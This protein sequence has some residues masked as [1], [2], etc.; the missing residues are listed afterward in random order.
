MYLYDIWSMDKRRLFMQALDLTDVKLTNGLFKERENLDRTYLMEL[1][2]RAL[3]QNFYLEAGIILPGLSQVSDPEGSYLHWGWEAPS[4]QLRGHFLGHFMSAAAH[5]CA[6]NKDRELEAKLYTI[7]DEL[8]KCQIENGGKWIGSIPEKYFKRLETNEYIWSPQY[9]LHKTLM[10]LLDVYECT[11]YELA[12]DILDNAADWYVDWV[13]QHKGEKAIVKGEAGG[14]LEIWARLYALTKKDKYLMLAESYSAYHDYE[15]LRKGEDALTDNHAN[16]SIPEAHGAAKMYEATGDEAWLDI[17]KEFWKQAIKDR[18]AYATGGQ[19]AGEFWIP[20][21]HFYEAMSDRDQEFCTMYNM[22]RLAE[23]LY[24]FTGER[25]YSDYIEKTLYNAFLTQQNSRTGMPAYF[26]PMKPASKKVWGS[27]THDFWCCHGTMVQAQTIYPKLIYYKDEAKN[28]VSVEQYINSEADF[29]LNDANVFISQEV[30]MDY[31]AGA[32]YGENNG[33]GTKTRWSFKFTVKSDKEIT[34]RF[35]VPAWANNVII[36]DGNKVQTSDEYYVM[37][38]KFDD[39]I[40]IAFISS[41]T[42][43]GLSDNENITAILDG[44]IVVAAV[45]ED[46]ASF[47]LDGRSL[48]EALTPFIEHT[49]EAYPWQQSSFRGY[50]NGRETL[51]LP[52]YAIT[53]EKYTIYVQK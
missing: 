41:L 28:V 48:D 4:C 49:Y 7:V 52:M 33:R 14:M 35:R 40:G 27:K 51:F 47:S 43:V 1:D 37:T 5:L 30:N 24:R 26:L 32:L 21:H 42:G 29:K 17:T 44:P 53:D 50:S 39:E 12:M 23:Y 18:E 13:S 22:V 3:L 25:E 9:T 38:K 31:C 2:N 45:G 36:V 34:L 10:G 16:A 8:K 20:P 46:G 11:G 15:L 19:N 6:V